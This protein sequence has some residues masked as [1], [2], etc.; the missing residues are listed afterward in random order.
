M[1]SRKKITAAGK[2]IFKTKKEKITR[3]TLREIKSNLRQN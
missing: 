2:I 3:A 1:H